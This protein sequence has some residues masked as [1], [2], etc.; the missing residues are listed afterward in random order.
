MG[1]SINNLEIQFLYCKI[2]T[3]ECSKYLQNG[4]S[5]VAQIVK[6][7]AA[8][9]EITVQSLGREGILDKGMAIYS[10]ILAWRIPWTEK[11]GELRSMGSFSVSDTTQESKLPSPLY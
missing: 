10:S 11:P 6:N 5:L 4:V 3:D 9:R 8:V 1:K 2:L 7:L